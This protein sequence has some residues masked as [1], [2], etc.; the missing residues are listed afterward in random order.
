MSILFSMELSGRTN[1]FLEFTITGFNI[2]RELAD[3][4]EQLAENPDSVD[5]YESQ[6]SELAQRSLDYLREGLE[7]FPED[8]SL[9]IEAEG[10]A[11]SLSGERKSTFALLFNKLL[12]ASV[13]D[14]VRPIDAISNTKQLQRAVDLTAIADRINDSN[15]YEKPNKVRELGDA[16]IGRVVLTM[17]SFNMDPRLL[18]IPDR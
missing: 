16:V 2:A 14:Q 11:R 5:D 4:D 12:Y 17:L 9:E 18:R 7:L 15:Y 10:L 13:S 8:F 1:P 6:L 3:I